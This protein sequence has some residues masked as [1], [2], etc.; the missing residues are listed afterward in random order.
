[1]LD[2]LFVAGFF[3][4]LI[5]DVDKVDELLLTRLPITPPSF[6]CTA[7]RDISRYRELRGPMKLSDANLLLD[8]FYLPMES[9]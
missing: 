4:G 5:P 3:S 9:G 8:H 6:C 7:S 2:F 1:M